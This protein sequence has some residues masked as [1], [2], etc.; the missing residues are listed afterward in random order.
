MKMP[1]RR[2]LSLLQSRRTRPVA[3]RQ[4]GWTA[5]RRTLEIFSNTKHPSAPTLTLTRHCLFVSH[6][7]RERFLAIPNKSNTHASFGAWSCCRLVCVVVLVVSRVCGE[8]Y[9]TLPYLTLS[10]ILTLSCSMQRAACRM[11][12]RPQNGFFCMD[13]KSDPI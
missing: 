4:S 2:Y 10:R 8:I 9:L 11:Q 1:F 13:A 3:G 12:N 5:P 7:E 6:W